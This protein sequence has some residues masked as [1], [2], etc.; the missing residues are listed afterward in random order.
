MARLFTP[1]RSHSFNHFEYST[2][3]ISCESFNFACLSRTDSTRKVLKTQFFKCAFQISSRVNFLRLVAIMKE[4]S[5]CSPRL[6][7]R[8]SS[9]MIKKSINEQMLSKERTL[10]E[11]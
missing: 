8:I 11:D 3:S 7:F 2:V 10:N 6:V 4:E 5:V 1:C 9:S